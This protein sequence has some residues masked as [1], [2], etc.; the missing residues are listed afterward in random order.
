MEDSVILGYVQVARK[1][2]DDWRVVFEYNGPINTNPLLADPVR[3]DHFLD[4]YSVRRTIRKGTH[5]QF[6][7]ALIEEPEFSAAIRNDSGQALDKLEEDLRRRFGVHNVRNRIISVM[8][9][10]AAFVRP[11]RFVAWDT[12]AKIGLN[13]VLGRSASSRFNNYAEYLAAFDEAWENQP[14]QEIRGCVTR[15][16][17]Q[18]VVE[19]EPRFLRRVLDVYLMK[20]GGRKLRFRSPAEPTQIEG[21]N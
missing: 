6:R 4:E 3:F 1:N 15:N 20:R 18:S 8:S 5:D 10:V 9:K 16:G 19:N 12:Y 17:A 7:L 11:E 14:G 13:K 2:W 21:T